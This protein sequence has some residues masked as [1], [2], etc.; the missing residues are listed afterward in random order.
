M[1]STPEYRPIDRVLVAN[2][3]EI[4]VRVIRACREM[5]LGTVAVCSEVDRM[6]LHAR[7]IQID[8]PSTGARLEWA[9]PARPR[10]RQRTRLDPL[11]D[12]LIVR[13]GIRARVVRAHLM[14]NYRR[15]AR[16]RM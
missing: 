1:S 11:G 15:R 3:G 12:R 2:R 14:N 10:D 16:Q 5:G 7:R 4:A 8:H 6:A 13:L 9:A